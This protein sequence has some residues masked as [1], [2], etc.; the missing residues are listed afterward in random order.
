MA[1]H[2]DVCVAAQGVLAQVVVGVHD[3]DLV[4]VRE[5]LGRGPCAARI[6]DDN[7][8]AANRLGQVRQSDADVDATKDHDRRLGRVRIHEDAQRPIGQVVVPELT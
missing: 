7:A 8:K 2:G 5:A 4:R 3:V 6:H 1:E